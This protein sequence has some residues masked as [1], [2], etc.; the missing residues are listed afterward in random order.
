MRYICTIGFL[1]CLL[2]GYAQDRYK[3][4]VWLA[5]KE[6]TEYSLEEPENYLSARALERRFRQNIPVDSTDLP[7]S[8]QY[9]KTL[10]DAGFPVVA[11]SRWLNS[12][13]VSVSDSN[14]VSV[15]KNYPFV[16]K[17]E[18]V[19]K[20]TSADGDFFV[21]TTVPEKKVKNISSP[22]GEALWQIARLEGDKLHNAGFKGEGIVIGVV[23]A[24]FLNVD[25]NP[26]IDK[27]KILGTRDFVDPTSDIYS[28]HNHGALTLSAMLG[29]IES[30]F[31]GTA[32]EAH[33]WLLRSE[34][35]N[36]EYPVEE[37]YWAAAVEFADSAGVDVINSSL[38]YYEFDNSLLNHTYDEFD[39]KTAFISKAAA[40]AVEKG[41]IVVNSAGNEGRRS[42]RKI[43]FPADVPGVL[44]VGAVDKDD[45]P[46]YFTGHGYIKGDVVKPDVAAL[47]LQAVLIGVD[48]SVVKSDGTSFSAPIIAG[49]SACLRQALPHLSSTEI[50]NRIRESSTLYSSP[51]T[52]SGY[53]FPRFYEAYTRE[54]SSLSREYPGADI[55]ITPAPNEM[56]VL[57][58]LPYA[59]RPYT[60]DVY[61]AYGIRLHRYFYQGGEQ[62][63]PLQ[64]LPPGLYLIQVSGENFNRGCKMIKK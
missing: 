2:A 48:G 15:L 9:I 52:L 13:V 56:L 5:D 44:A 47:G 3:F 64:F 31:R 25:K 30:V 23:D 26:G 17:I 11:S 50:V 61:S 54:A 19:W 57:R 43:I 38:G 6:G 12:V 8:R 29:E 49:L 7:V 20:N 16:R 10:N 55:Y 36:S 41:I 27:S 34:D 45:A 24:G 35:S 14:S 37:D 46:A 63:I 22:Y 59:A 42:W 33:Y 39:G 21:D 1:L 60:V 40:K 28:V 58:N 18:C 62:L 4:R 53:G 32:P 51:D